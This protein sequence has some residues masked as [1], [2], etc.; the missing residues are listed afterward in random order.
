MNLVRFD[1]NLLVALDALLKERN[2]TRAGQRIGLSQ[3]AMSGTLARLRELFGDEL[4]VRV[5]RHL[6]LTPRAQELVEPLRQ[7]I[8]RIEDMIDH[9]RAFSASEERRSFTIA[10]SDYATFLLLPPLLKRLES[11]A[12]GITVKFTRLNGNAMTELGEGRV[13]FVIMP[14]EIETSFPGEL[15]FI[16][17]WV[18]AAWSKHPDIG[19]RL[20]EKQYLALPHLGFE[21][22]EGD[23]RSVADGHLSYL[24][25]RRHIVA[26]TESFLLAPFMLRGTRFVTLA[27]QRLAERV[28]A[29]A[30]IRLLDPPYTL[31]DIHESIYWNPRHGGAPPHQ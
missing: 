9:R 23:G 25:V 13:D 6:E 5:G 7:C 22:P 16:D 30:D 15:L 28:K 8:E 2:V 1:L 24:Q 31:P 3:P 29:A 20:T 11:E 21:M 19:G 12:P 27:H 18:C 4:L 10:A 26:T 14:S 17:R